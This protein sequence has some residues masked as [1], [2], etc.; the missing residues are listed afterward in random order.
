MLHARRGSQGELRA[1]GA[2]RDEKAVGSPGVTPGDP[3]LLRRASTNGAKDYRLPINC[4][5]IV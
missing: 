3:D 1:V 5:R 2:R 4:C